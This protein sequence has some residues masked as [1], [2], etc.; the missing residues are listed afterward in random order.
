M[1]EKIKKTTQDT[2]STFDKIWN[3]TLLLA[4]ATA[5]V[6]GAVFA[7]ELD[8]PHRAIVVAVACILAANVVLTLF[9][10]Q[11]EVKY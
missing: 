7:M 5:A 9:R 3:V 2:L 6:L 11:R 4:Q 1:V 10:L 8:N